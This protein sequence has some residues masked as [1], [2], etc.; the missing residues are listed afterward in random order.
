MISLL[1]LCLFFSMQHLGLIYNSNLLRAICIFGSLLLSFFNS[2]ILVL[3]YFLINRNL[4]VLFNLWFSLNYL[5]CQFL[6]NILL[7]IRYFL[8]KQLL[9]NFFRLLLT[10]RNSKLL[11]IC[12][13]VAFHLYLSITMIV[14][15]LPL[16][17]L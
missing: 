7:L 13:S 15:L 16:Q 1:T 8:L 3:F 14:L 17:S 10:R 5:M 6:L 9:F 2:I 11:G 4:F 12:I